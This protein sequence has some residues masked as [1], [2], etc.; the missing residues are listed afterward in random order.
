MPIPEI[1]ELKR[2][3][4]AQLDPL[5]LYLFGSFAEGRDTQDSD[6][7]LYIVVEDDAQ[8]LAA[9]TTAAYRAVRKIKKRPVDIVV[10]RAAQFEVRKRTPSVENEVYRKGV[11]LYES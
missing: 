10:G 4:V 2:A 5:R 11:L 6:L 8:D 7:D 1:E 9:L 3:L